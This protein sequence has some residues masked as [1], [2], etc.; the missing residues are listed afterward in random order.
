MVRV[1]VQLH[2]GGQARRGAKDIVPAV[3][4]ASTNPFVPSAS[5]MS[6]LGVAALW[7]A[8][9]Y[10]LVRMREAELSVRPEDT[11]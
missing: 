1:R 3:A 6:W 2:G 7:I 4:R 10:F 11:R 8:A 9:A 5:L